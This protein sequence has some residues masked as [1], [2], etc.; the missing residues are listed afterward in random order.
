MHLGYIIFIKP[1]WLFYT[2]KMSPINHPSITF[3]IPI[4]TIVPS[5]IVVKSWVVPLW[6]WVPCLQNMLL[7]SKRLIQWVVTFYEGAYNEII[8]F[9]CYFYNISTR[10][11]QKKIWKKKRFLEKY[12]SM[13]KFGSL[14]NVLNPLCW[15]WL[16]AK[17]KKVKKKNIQILP[18]DNFMH[19]FHLSS[20]RGFTFTFIFVLNVNGFIGYFSSLEVYWKFPCSI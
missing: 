18:M 5:K 6:V 17:R 2:K 19:T 7:V 3:L 11:K 20:Q 9:F 15:V 4:C 8:I 14:K 10:L 13:K 16:W 12:I 1:V